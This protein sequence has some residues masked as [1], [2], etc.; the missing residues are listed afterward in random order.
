M[1][2]KIL[3]LLGY[4]QCAVRDERAYEYNEQEVQEAHGRSPKRKEKIITK[5]KRIIPLGKM[6]MCCFTGNEKRRQF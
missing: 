5:M 4:F 3:S 1:M 2:K 6:E